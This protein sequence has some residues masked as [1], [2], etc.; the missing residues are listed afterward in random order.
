MGDILT[1]RYVTHLISVGTLSYFEKNDFERVERR[2]HVTLGTLSTVEREDW[3]I[4]HL[5]KD[6]DVASQNQLLDCIKREY[7]HR[8][9]LNH[10][11]KVYILLIIFLFSYSL[12]LI[13]FSYIYLFFN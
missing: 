13:F 10:K 5:Y 11:E 6:G 3:K 2:I 4:K 8:M 1:P 12:I 7:K 9:S